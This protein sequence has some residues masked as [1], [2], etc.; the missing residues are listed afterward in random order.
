MKWKVLVGVGVVLS[1][2]G[3]VW[4]LQ[5]LNQLGGSPMT[6]GAFWAWVGLASLIAGLG[7]LYVAFRIGR[8]PSD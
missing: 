7:L 8:K 1:L 2:T 6:G 4:I 3:V 5:G